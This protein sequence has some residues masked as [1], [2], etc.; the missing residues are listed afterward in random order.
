MDARYTIV[1]WIVFICG[2]RL[3]GTDDDGVSPDAVVRLRAT[4]C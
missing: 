1:P 3:P 4:S 2:N